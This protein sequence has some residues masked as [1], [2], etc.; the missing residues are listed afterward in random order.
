LDEDEEPAEP[1]D[2]ESDNGRRR[3]RWERPSNET[4]TVVT[5][6]ITA[7]GALIG[8]LHQSGVI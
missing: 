7:I 3:R 8:A 2:E 1:G 5:E 6:L 4:L